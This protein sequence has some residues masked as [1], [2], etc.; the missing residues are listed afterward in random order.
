[1]FHNRALLTSYRV[2]LSDSS[3]AKH[4]TVSADKNRMFQRENEG[5][6]VMADIDTLYSVLG[7]QPRVKH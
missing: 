7:V 1:M 6:S 4:V 3:A 5:N 2:S